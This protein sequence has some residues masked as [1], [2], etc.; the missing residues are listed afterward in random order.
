MRTSADLA[1]DIERSRDLEFVV[2]V[3]ETLKQ[4]IDREDTDK[5]VQIT[6]EDKGPKVSRSMS[7][8]SLR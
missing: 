3:D 7:V 8:F 4:L 1:I 5:N 6:V 2:Y